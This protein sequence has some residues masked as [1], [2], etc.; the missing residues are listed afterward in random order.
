MKTKIFSLGKELFLYINIKITF[1]NF[2]I[3]LLFLIPTIFV[4]AVIFIG[5]IIMD[6]K[7][8]FVANFSTFI[9]ILS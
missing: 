4:I 3:F 1:I 6:I 8:I 5:T 7:N 9:F 2:T